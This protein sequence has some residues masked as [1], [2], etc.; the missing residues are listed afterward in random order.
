VRKYIHKNNAETA[1]QVNKDNGPE[2]NTDI[3]MTLNISILAPKWH[4]IHQHRTKP[5][6]VTV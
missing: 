4:N 2:K 6:S 3:C 5:K 1:L